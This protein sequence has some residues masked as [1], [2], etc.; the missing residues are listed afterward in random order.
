MA[1]GSDATKDPTFQRVIQT[2]LNTPPERNKPKTEL[3]AGKTRRAVTAAETVKP[4]PKSAAK[5]KPRS[6]RPAG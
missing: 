6:D 1:K 3:K 4:K 2:F 5:K